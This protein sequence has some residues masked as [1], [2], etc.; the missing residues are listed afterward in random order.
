M[1]ESPGQPPRFIPESSLTRGAN[2]FV[3]KERCP[4]RGRAGEAPQVNGCQGVPVTTVLESLGVD[5]FGYLTIPRPNGTV[6]YLAASDFEEFEGEAP[7]LFS[8]EKSSATRFWRPPRAGDPNDI[9]AEDNIATPSGEALVVGVHYGHVVGVEVTASTTSTNA[10]SPVQFTASASGGM[11]GEEFTYHWTFGDGTGGEGPTPSHTFGGSGTYVVRVTA[12]GS[13]DSGG[14]SGPVDIVVGNPPSTAQ[15]GATMT[16]EKA[17][18]KPRGA[19]G[20]GHE[21]T[22]GKGSR[23][24]S[25]GSKEKKRGD[26]SAVK[27][28]KLP[29]SRSEPSAPTTSTAAPE[30]AA[31]VPPPAS[32]VTEE[33]SETAPAGSGTETGTGA[34]QATETSPSGGELVEG[35][36][37]G[38]HLGSTAAVEAGDP[39]S[40]QG[41]P[42]AAGAVG[43]G[44]VGV[45]VVLLMVVG[46]LAAGALFEWRGRTPR[47]RA[48]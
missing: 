15:P 39:S 21:G 17:P 42:S 13:K 24:S 16:P 45:P 14:E 11:P 10:G 29:A 12:L 40:G 5:S 44:G 19:P 33:S 34:K 27:R 1:V 6:A 18:P 47:R 20:K 43:S 36:L 46:L 26:D 23:S 31:A 7:P 22:G 32:P 30:V 28:G 9:N 3:E 25:G 41:S 38:D 35:R 8:V 37:V 4:L 48:R 2:G